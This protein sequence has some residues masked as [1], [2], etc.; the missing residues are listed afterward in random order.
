MAAQQQLWWR[1]CAVNGAA[2][3]LLGAFGAHALKSRVD[4][5]MVVR[6]NTGAHYHQIHAV[7][8]AVAVM[9]G[10]FTS[11]SLFL[12]GTLLFSGSLYA[13]VLTGE[14]KWRGHAHRRIVANWRLA[15][16]GKVAV[17]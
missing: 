3:I 5:E 10:R 1:I 15:S 8:L 4:A 13:M 2:S 12:A 17:E 16:A 9:N 14:K 7:A 11:A 6:W